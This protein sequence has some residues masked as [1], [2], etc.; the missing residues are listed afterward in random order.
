MT[1]R[2]R[3][4]HVIVH[5]NVLSWLLDARPLPHA[6]EA[7]RTVGQRAVPFVTVA[8]LRY[9]VLLAGRGE[10]RLHRLQLRRLQRSLADL[11]VAHCTEALVHSYTELRT[12]ATRTGHGLGH[13]TH[14]AGRW[15]ASRALALGIELVAGDGTFEGLAGLDVNRTRRT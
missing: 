5:T 1:V 2:R 13:K 6:D 14:E 8:E 15:V 7:W 11:D 10:L 9:G 3:D 12:H 4:S